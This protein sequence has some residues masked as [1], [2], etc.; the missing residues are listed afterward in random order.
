MASIL[1]VADQWDPHADKVSGLLINLGVTVHRLDLNPES[2]RQVT[3]ALSKDG[4]WIDLPLGRV[5]LNDIAAVWSRRTT[6][7]LSLQQEYEDKSKSFLIWKNEWNRHLFWIYHELSSIYWLNTLV[8]GALADNKWHQLKLARE[9]GFDVPDTLSSNARE[10]LQRFAN[11]RGPVALKF[12]SQSMIPAEAGFLGLF[13]NR[14]NSEYLRDFGGSEEQPVVLQ[15]YLEKQYEVRYTVVGKSHYVCRIDSQKSEIASVDWRRYDLGNTPHFS[16][17][18]PDRIRD[19]VSALMARL[20]LDYGALDFVVD[21]LG[22]W[23]FLEINSNGQWL[24][25]EELTG[26]EISLGIANLLADKTRGK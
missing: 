10:E 4:G 9:I 24:W 1:I 14:I 7:A 3:F 26:L 18:P 15:P 16:I 2:L 8:D 25:I 19:L 5:V 23:W 20:G 17:I 13:V 6:I 11:T 12:L 21:G 22:N